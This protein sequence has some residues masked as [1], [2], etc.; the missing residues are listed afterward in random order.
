M[1][2]C[3]IFS[4]INQYNASI[5]D[6]RTAYKNNNDFETWDNMLPFLSIVDGETTLKYTPYEFTVS[7]NGEDPYGK[8][9]QRGFLTE[10]DSYHQNFDI[11][12]PY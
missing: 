4:N 7:V 10:G 9:G 3:N 5:G 8:Y 2:H 1:K 11:T 12:V 6:V